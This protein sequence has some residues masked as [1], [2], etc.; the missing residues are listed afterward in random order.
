M[1]NAPPSSSPQEITPEM[2]VAPA[3]LVPAG[4]GA[5]FVASFIDGCILS[6]AGFALGLAIGFAG[7]D[8]TVSPLLAL[9]LQIGYFTLMV[10]GGGQTLGKKAMKIKVLTADG[11]PV[12]YGRAFVRWAGY[13]P[14][15]LL[16]GGGY[17][18]ALFTQDNRALHDFIAGTR[19]VAVG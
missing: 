8:A 19:V 14:S 18:M 6:I 4:F 11:G 3:Q 2:Q 15:A 7:I 16:L 1:D 9:A 17:L 10:G 13:I 5:R 12:G